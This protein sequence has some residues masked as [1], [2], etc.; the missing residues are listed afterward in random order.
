MS[1]DSETRPKKIL[2]IDDD[3]SIVTFF[4]AL[5]QENGYQTCTASDGEEA[6]RVFRAEKPD[7]ITLDIALPKAW[8]PL[9]HHRMVQEGLTPPPIIVVS[10]MQAAKH[11]VPGA[12]AVLTK[13]V[14]PEKLLACVRDILG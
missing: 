3:P 13:P 7:L 4:Q 6:L 1:P 9:F 5:F 2:I 12:R 11:A 10:G 14:G 8:G